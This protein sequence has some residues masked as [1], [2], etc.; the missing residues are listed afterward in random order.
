[1]YPGRLIL[2][3]RHAHTALPLDEEQLAQLFCVGCE[4]PIVSE[5]WTATHLMEDSDDS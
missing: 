2:L 3:S 4:M 5:I 1:M